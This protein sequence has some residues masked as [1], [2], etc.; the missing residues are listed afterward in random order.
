MALHEED[1]AAAAR[2]RWAH[3]APAGG[4]TLA[5]RSRRR[6]QFREGKSL[7]APILKGHLP[8]LCL[9]VLCSSAAGTTPGCGCTWACCRRYRRGTLRR[10]TAASRSCRWVPDCRSGSPGGSCL[11]NSAGGHF[12]GRRD[13][14]GHGLAGSMPLLPRPHQLHASWLQLAVR[15]VP[16]VQAAIMQHEEDERRQHR[17][18]HERGGKNGGGGGWSDGPSYRQFY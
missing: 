18:H 7:N 2:I 13:A 8:T 10:Q 14:R 11:Y 3:A 12:L 16:A 15:A 4:F 9:P 5:V 6:G 1:Y 17:A